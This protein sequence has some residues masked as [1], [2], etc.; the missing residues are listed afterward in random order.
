MPH[1]RRVSEG[2]CLRYDFEFVEECVSIIDIK[3]TCVYGIHDKCFFLERFKV[4][5][6][7]FLKNS[8]NFI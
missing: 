3:L 4:N 6:V 8:F 2:K 5:F 1:V 7:I